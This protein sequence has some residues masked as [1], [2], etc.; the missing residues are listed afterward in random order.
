M[1][2]Q[3]QYDRVLEV[4]PD[5]E[6]IEIREVNGVGFVVS[7]DSIHICYPATLEDA[8]F[9]AAEIATLVYHASG[10]MSLPIVHIQWGL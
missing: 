8:Y 7:L 1:L 9:N 10:G 6:M 3:V 5:K 2:T 4:Y